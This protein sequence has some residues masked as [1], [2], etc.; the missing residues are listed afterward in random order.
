MYYLIITTIR[1]YWLYTSR[2]FCLIHLLVLGH[3]VYLKIQ[4]PRPRVSSIV[5]IRIF[6]SGFFL[7]LSLQKYTLRI[8]IYTNINGA[9]TT[10]SQI[11]PTQR[12]HESTCTIC[13]YIY[14]LIEFANKLRNAGN[15]TFTPLIKHWVCN[16]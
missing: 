3:I 1:L 13:I 6:P 11:Q 7:V 16:D 2:W 10:F 8:R 9:F 14:E 15:S 12:T 4:S 5:I